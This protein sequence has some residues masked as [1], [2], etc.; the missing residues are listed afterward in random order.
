MKYPIVLHVVTIV[1]NYTDNSAPIGS[2][3][4]DTSYPWLCTLLA[5]TTLIIRIINDC[6][7]NYICRMKSELDSMMKQVDTAGRYQL[8]LFLLFAIVI[9]IQSLQVMSPT[10]TFIKP[11]FIC[12]GQVWS[13]STTIRNVMIMS[14][15]VGTMKLWYHHNLNI[16]TLWLN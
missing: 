4:L 3:F 8:L 12:N 2:I 11:H 14:T 5:M 1:S 7:I 6:I 13:V 10:Y 15:I 9:G 16:R